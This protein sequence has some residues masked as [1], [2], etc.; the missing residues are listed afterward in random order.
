MY[1]GTQPW[2]DGPRVFPRRWP[3]AQSRFGWESSWWTS[4]VRRVWNSPSW[5]GRMSNIVSIV[6]KP[7]MSQMCIEFV[8]V[9]SSRCL[10]ATV[11]TVK[12]SLTSA[13]SQGCY[14]IDSSGCCPYSYWLS[15]PSGWWSVVLCALGMVASI[16]SW[17]TSLLTGI[18]ATVFPLMG[19]FGGSGCSMPMARLRWALLISLYF[20]CSLAFSQKILSFPLGVRL[21]EGS[22]CVWL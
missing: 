18:L 1:R 8:M 14:R 19:G 7:A 20:Q 6:C 21:W 15:V 4:V 16:D 2:S 22:V 12:A 10:E 9:P 13:D 11:N 17:K 5:S 3:V